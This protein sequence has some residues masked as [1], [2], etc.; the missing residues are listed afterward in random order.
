MI[1]FTPSNVAGARDGVITRVSAAGGTPMHYGM[2]AYAIVRDSEAEAKRELDR[3]LE[4][5]AIIAGAAG[6]KC[7]PGGQ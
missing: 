2:A 4:V 3:I 6:K 5:R 7:Q 1:L